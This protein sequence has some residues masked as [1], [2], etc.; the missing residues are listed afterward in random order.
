MNIPALLQ[1]ELLEYAS[2]LR[3]IRTNFTLN[4]EPQ[5]TSGNPHARRPD[6]DSDRG[7]GL[8]VKKTQLNNLEV[9]C[10]AS[11]LTQGRKL[12]SNDK[13]ISEY[14]AAEMET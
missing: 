12:K 10:E 14:Q 2:L 13:S 3:A 9:P 1:S 8:T 6:Y 5:L 11:E 7:G 4:I